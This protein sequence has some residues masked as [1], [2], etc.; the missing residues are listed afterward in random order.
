[1][2]AAG[3]TCGLGDSG[4]APAKD[5]EEKRL[6]NWSASPFGPEVKLKRT[7]RIARSFEARNGLSSIFTI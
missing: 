1:M 2:E 6:G 3:R 7:A 4:R 5:A